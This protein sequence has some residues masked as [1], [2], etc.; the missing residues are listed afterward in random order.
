[1]R[2][3]V[4]P[5]LYTFDASAKTLTFTGEDEISLTRLL[6]VTNLTEG[7]DIF[8]S[9]D[10][11]LSGVVTD[12]AIEFDFDTTT[13]NDADDLQVW[14]EFDNVFGRESDAAITTDVAGTISGKLR[15]LIKIFA[16]VWDSSNH[17]LNV[18]IKSKLQV[19]ID[20]EENDTV[21]SAPTRRGDSFNEKFNDDDASAG[22]VL[23]AGSAG[24]E[25]HIT[26]C[27]ISVDTEMTVTIRDEDDNV[28][29]GPLYLPERGTFGKTY[30]TPIPVTADKDIEVIASTAGNITVN[31]GGYDKITT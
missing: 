16:D 7:E 19:L 8:D 21:G 5:S 24:A 31:L 3:L 4:D 2:V 10:P 23:H 25:A 22:A 30:N 18:S 26:D 14:Y 12:N 28:L 9:T 17:W 20:N 11:D 27:T 13:M 1:M 15:G 6:L 29:I